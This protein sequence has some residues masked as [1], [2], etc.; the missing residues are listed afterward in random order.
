MAK[1]MQS[2]VIVKRVLIC[3]VAV[4]LTGCLRQELQTGLTEQEAQEIIV[5]LKEH[6]IDSDRERDLLSGDKGPPL[7]KV[8]VKGGDQNLVLAWKIL[9]ENG[10]PRQKA[11]GLEEV[12]SQTGLI[13]TAS[14][15]KARMLLALSGEIG[16]TLKSVPGVVDARVQIVLPENSPILDKAD[17]KPTTAS[18]LLKYIWPQPPIKE[19]DVRN[20]VA[21]GV[22]GLTAENVAVVFHKIEPRPEPKHSVAW[23]LGNQQYL[24]VS[25][26]LLTVSS[27]GN[28]ALTIRGR[29][30]RRVIDRLRL[31]SK[32]L[33][34]GP[35]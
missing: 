28:L 32:R 8:S 19:T 14:E 10:L 5:L 3:C 27:L 34:S 21:K 30:Q 20:L 9:Q 13:P 11:K 16:R 7:Y 17:W 24:V 2:A 1:S 15:E 23:Y 18:V 4:M 25:L 22:E 26:A 31:E 12:F 6:G 35:Q 33:P 29:Q